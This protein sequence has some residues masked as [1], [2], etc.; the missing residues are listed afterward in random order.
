MTAGSHHRRIAVG[1]F[2]VSLF[3]LIGKLAGAAKEMAVAW[4][5]GVGGTVDAYAFLYN[6]MNW[7]VSVWFSVLTVVL[8]PL[9]ARVGRE[10]P[11]ELPRFAGE[12]LGLSIVGGVVLAL[13]AI[14]GLPV[15]F[16]HGSVAIGADGLVQA[17]AMV[18]P[19]SAL[20]P[21]GLAISVASAWTMARGRHRN[22][23][24]EAV[25]SVILLVVLALPSGV[26]PAP[27]AWGT[28]AGSAVHVLCLAWPLWRQGEVGRPVFAFTSPAWRYF[29][30]GIGV[31]VVGQALTALTT[32]VDQFFAGSLGA[33]AISV[34]SYATRL[35]TLILGLGAMAISRAT[36]PI[37]SELTTGKDTGDV[38]RLAAQWTKIMFVLGALGFAVAWFL[39]PM[40]VRL[41]FERG[42]FDASDTE[43]V[44]AVFRYLGFQIPFYFA[45][46]VL[47]A[48]FSAL[49]KYRIVA[50][51]G[52]ANMAVKAVLLYLLVPSYGLVGVCMSTVLMYVISLV[53]FLIL[54][55]RLGAQHRS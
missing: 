31:M 39:A 14:V 33:G 11:A 29:W 6:L 15:L 36:L 45:S 55:R 8:V 49:G 4:R 30:G 32:I 54:H 51:S 21:L 2:W 19:L 47:I 20:L 18:G 5:Y 3:V 9:V 17:Q 43:K 44:A 12:L 40:G 42:A 50:F 25:P 16:A 24:L 38:F 35:M 10:S 27:L 52:A 48:H 1:F 53:F 41:L 46:L 37:F 34:L 7:P 22:T 28:V 13:A 26:I 23:L